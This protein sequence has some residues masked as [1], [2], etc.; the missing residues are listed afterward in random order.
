MGCLET[1]VSLVLLVIQRYRCYLVL[2]SAINL[3]QRQG[4]H[5]WMDISTLYLFC[6]LIFQQ[7]FKSGKIQLN[8][9]MSKDRGTTTSRERSNS[10]FYCVYC[11]GEC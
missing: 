3:N 4:E 10:N 5:S 7:I 9:N 11:W 8:S 1:N 6:T 2:S